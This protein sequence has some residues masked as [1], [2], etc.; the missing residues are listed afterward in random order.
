MTHQDQRPAA[1]KNVLDSR[2]GPNDPVVAR[3]VAVLVQRHVK[4]APHKDLLS[5]DI[6]IGNRLFRHLP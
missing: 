5:P 4:I 6:D 2:K 1:I 3:N